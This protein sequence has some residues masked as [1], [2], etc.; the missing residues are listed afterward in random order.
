[1]DS[2]AILGEKKGVLVSKGV[3]EGLLNWTIYQ[4]GH[5]EEP[6]QLQIVDKAFVIYYS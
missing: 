3:L 2:S 5:Q 1:M 6:I 4:Y